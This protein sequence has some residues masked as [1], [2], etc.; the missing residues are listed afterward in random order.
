MQINKV[1]MTITFC[2]AMLLSVGV[3]G[4]KANLVNADIPSKQEELQIKKENFQKLHEEY[5]NDE[6]ATSEQGQ[7]IKDL[8]MEI[9]KLENEISPKNP[10]DVLKGKLK[11][12]KSMTLIHQAAYK[13]KDQNDPDVNKMLNKIKKRLQMVERFQQD[14]ENINKSPENLLPEDMNKASE[15]LLEEFQKAAL[16]L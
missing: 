5:L 8:G 6:N 13:E 1:M 3:L 2:S 4:Y 7:K 11:A 10:E 12:Y 14:L 15:K 16:K 9:G